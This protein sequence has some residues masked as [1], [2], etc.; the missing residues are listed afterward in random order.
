MKHT[1]SAGGVVINPDG[2]VL[3]V[4]QNSDSW[5][6][7][8]GNIEPGEDEEAAARR[9]TREESGVTELTL[10]KKLG[11][12]Q[13]HRISQGGVGETEDLKN[14]TMFLFTTTQIELKPEDPANP[15]ARWVKPEAVEEMLTHPKDRE[16]FRSI[17][18]DLYIP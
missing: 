12:Y 15:E 5:S 1:Y 14:I 3:V 6:L 10:I 2:L 4:N 13:R 9:E 8:K 11:T 18:S 7:P 17:S 16:F